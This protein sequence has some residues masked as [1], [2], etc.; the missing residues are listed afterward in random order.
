MTEL[1]AQ[2]HELLPELDERS[3]RLR[4][5]ADSR[6]PDLIVERKRAIRGIVDRERGVFDGDETVN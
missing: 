4:P 1:E 5:R 2:L 3:A 6:K